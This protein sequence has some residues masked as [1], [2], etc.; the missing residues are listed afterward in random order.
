[1]LF[2]L[3]SFKIKAHFY[4]RVLSKSLFWSLFDQNKVSFF[5]SCFQSCEVTNARLS[6]LT[7]GLMATDGLFLFGGQ[8]TIYTGQ[9]EQDPKHLNVQWTMNTVQFPMNNIN[10]TLYTVQCTVLTVNRTINTWMC[11]VHC[12]PWCVLCTLH[13]TH[14]T[15]QRTLETWI[16]T[17]QCALNTKHLYVY[18]TVYMNM[19]CIKGDCTKGILRNGVFYKGV[20]YKRD[21]VKRSFVQ[22]GCSK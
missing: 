1:M 20:L 4:D 19:E 3:P 10:C 11:N 18:C 13:C 16:F 17:V 14:Y 6:A 22:K 9:C 7:G 2:S 15:V 8:T 5:L 12:T 21:V